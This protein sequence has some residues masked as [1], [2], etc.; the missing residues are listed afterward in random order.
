MVQGTPRHLCLS[1]GPSCVLRGRKICCA[2]ELKSDYCL[3][4]SLLL[5]L[6]VSFYKKVFKK[7]IMLLF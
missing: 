6:S 2:L 3:F 4:V 1:V 7:K 5:I